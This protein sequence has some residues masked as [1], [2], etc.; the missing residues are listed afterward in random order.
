MEQYLVIS[1]N[2]YPTDEVL[3]AKEAYIK[4]TQDIDLD[5]PIKPLAEYFQLGKA[6]MMHTLLHQ[7]DPKIFTEVYKTGHEWLAI[8]EQ[9]PNGKEEARIVRHTLKYQKPCKYDVYPHPFTSV[10][11]D[12]RRKDVNPKQNA[13]FMLDRFYSDIYG[14]ILSCNMFYQDDAQYYDQTATKTADE[15]KG[16]LDKYKIMDQRRMIERA[17]DNTLVDP[18]AFEN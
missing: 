5:V 12:F 9:F 13:E 11:V 7:N 2:L 3:A 4:R 1:N 15:M 18:K 6:Y 10:D 16:L 14:L 17:A 8:M